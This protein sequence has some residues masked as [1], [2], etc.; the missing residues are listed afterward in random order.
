M[1]D[2]MAWGFNGYSYDIENASKVVIW[3][4][5]MMNTTN[6]EP[7]YFGQFTGVGTYIKDFD[8]FTEKEFHLLVGYEDDV[9][10]G[11]PDSCE[12]GYVPLF[13][14]CYSIM[15]TDSINLSG[16]SLTDGVTA[17]DANFVYSGD[18]IQRFNSTGLLLDID[19]DKSIDALTDGLLILRFL[20]G[21]RGENLSSDAL[22][23]N[24]ER[25]T[26]RELEEYLQALTN[27]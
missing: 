5:S 1:I 23:P 13:G 19:D 18:L 2:Y 21:I 14:N 9:S 8:D 3:N 26:V 16:Q 22:S 7:G 6:L 12:S 17:P 27:Q 24:A 20:F 10:P 4:G 15:E 11:T 25:N